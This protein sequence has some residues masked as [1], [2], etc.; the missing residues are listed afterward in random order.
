MEATIKLNGAKLFPLLTA[1]GEGLAIDLP[2][3]VPSRQAGMHWVNRL[4]I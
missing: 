2:H 1:A 4:I 3:G